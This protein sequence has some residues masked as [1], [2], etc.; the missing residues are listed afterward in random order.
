MSAKPVV[1][2]RHEAVVA[3]SYEKGG[4]SA[5][6]CDH[7]HC[8]HTAISIPAP[9]KVRIPVSIDAN[10]LLGIAGMKLPLLAVRQYIRPPLPRAQ[11]DRAKH[12]FS[13]NH[14]ENNTAVPGEWA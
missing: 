11:A 8:K 1:Q 2:E 9:C 12:S 10:S 3:P 14:C 5:P 6:T 7:F 13:A 4:G